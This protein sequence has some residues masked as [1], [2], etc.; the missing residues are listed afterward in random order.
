M[1]ACQK[2]VGGITWPKNTH[3]QSQF[4]G[5]N[6]P[7]TPVLFIS[8]IRCSFSMDEKEAEQKRSLRSEK[9]KANGAS[10][11]E[12]QR[13]RLRIRREKDREEGNQKTTRG[14]QKIVRNTRP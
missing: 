10:E 2:Y 9:L 8:T 4:G 7:V 14:K 12:E 11:T 1:Q 3:A 13:N 6:R 5:V